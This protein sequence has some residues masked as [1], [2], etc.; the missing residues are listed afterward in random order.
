MPTNS[1][2]AAVL[3]SAIWLFYFFAA[4]LDNIF[5][6]TYSADSANALV[7]LLGTLSEDGLTYTVGWFCF[8]S[9]ELAIITLYAFYI[10]IFIKMYTFE[11]L[12]TFKR[13]VMP[14]L[15]I[16]GSLFMIFAAIYAHRW[17]ALYYL[18]ITT[19]ILLIGAAYMKKKDAE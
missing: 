2:V 4:N 14:T 19:V 11:F 15:A 6:A 10:P 5:V 7:R 12:S 3:I 16:I 1:A 17:G 13:F 8:D 18:I 9:S